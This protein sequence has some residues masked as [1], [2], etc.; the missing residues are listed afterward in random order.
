[1]N[2]EIDGSVGERRETEITELGGVD[3]G[4]LALDHVLVSILGHLQQ[5]LRIG[6]SKVGQG[7]AHGCPSNDPGCVALEL[8]LGV[9]EVDLLGH[10]G[11]FVVGSL[12]PV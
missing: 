3:H 4:A 5:R 1:M 9:G 2:S 6:V 11:P 8:L 7:D 10:N 12:Y